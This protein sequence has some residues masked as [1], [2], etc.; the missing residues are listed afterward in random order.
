MIRL[1]TNEHAEAEYIA[2]ATQL[3]YACHLA[4]R[5][6]KYSRAPV[7][8]FPF[9]IEPAIWLSQIRFLFDH[10]GQPVSY[11]TFAFLEASV[12]RRL[13]EDPRVILHISEWKEGD[14]VWVLDLVALPGYLRN[15]LNHVVT[16][17]PSSEPI[18]Y[19][20][21]YD[22]GRVRK[23]VTVLRKGNRYGLG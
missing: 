11:Y 15:T 17:L 21:R 16:T 6:R 1:E 9:W 3:G 22:D 19:L 5:T 13:I 2:Y 12:E 14:R 4:S 18:K 20:R 7:A 8:V 10:R 23:A